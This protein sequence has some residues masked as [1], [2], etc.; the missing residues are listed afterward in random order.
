MYLFYNIL[1]NFLLYYILDNI[2][3]K[4]VVNL[5]EFFYNNKILKKNFK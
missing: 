3:Y 2:S 4:N 1:L 5:K